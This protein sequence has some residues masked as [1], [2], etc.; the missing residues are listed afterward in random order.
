MQVSRS[1]NPENDV[2]GRLLFLPTGA[3]APASSR[4]FW[5]ASAGST[6]RLHLGQSI[7]PGPL[8]LRTPDNVNAA[9][10]PDISDERREMPTID[11]L[12]A[13]ALLT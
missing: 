10:E 8:H 6:T 4:S 1:E 9:I 3:G 7:V 2:E 13:T 12:A 11:P 5:T